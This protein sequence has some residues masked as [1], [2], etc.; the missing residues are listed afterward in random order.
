MKQVKSSIFSLLIVSSLFGIWNKTSDAFSWPIEHLFDQVRQSVEKE[1]IEVSI[2]PFLEHNQ[3]S[4]LDIKE[5][6]LQRIERGEIRME[7]GL[8]AILS[9]HIPEELAE[10]K[11]KTAPISENKLSLQG[12]TSRKIV[13]AGLELNGTPFCEYE[14]KAFQN[15]LGS[16]SMIGRLPT[17]P[18]YATFSRLEDWPDIHESWALAKEE[19]TATT[20]VDNEEPKL[21]SYKRCYD[22]HG[23]SIVGLWKIVGRVA[24]RSYTVLTDN[25]QVY[26]ISPLYFEVDG[27]IQA[28]RLNPK[29]GQLATFTTKLT[30][31]GYLRSTFFETNTDSNTTT[32]EDEAF[33]QDHNF[34]YQPNEPEFAEASVFIHA[35][36]MLAFFQGLGYGFV[37]KQPI[38]LEVHA[39][40]GNNQNNALYQPPGAVYANQ[41]VISIGDG[42]G[43]V[44]K[45]LALDSDVVSHEFGHH[46]VFN[47]LKTTSGDS[48]VLH[49][50]LADFFAFS[51][52]SDPCLGESICP[53]GST[54]CMIESSCLRTADLNLAYGDSQYEILGPHLKGQV[55]SG[56]L[57]NLRESMG[58]ES[59]TNV[60]YSALDYFVRDTGYQDFLVSLM[61]ADQDLNQGSNACTIYDAAVAKGLSSFLQ[62]IDCN[63]SS[64]WPSPGSQQSSGNS[65]VESSR[66]SSSSDSDFFNCGAIGSGQNKNSSHL[67]LLVLF[68]LPLLA[69]ALI[70]KNPRIG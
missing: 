44:L 50:G 56:M 24:G 60:T 58:L 61:L 62:G 49:E 31:D 64:S 13:S 5:R 1:T 18:P 30:G 65:T 32:A 66:N 17:L 28:Y 67:S 69:L 48:L 9:K 4:L 53:A 43:S 20:F 47:T 51:R 39:V 68:L 8:I 38:L 70:G 45:N 33:S 57:W 21:I 41:A 22:V 34:I 59:I 63:N 55:V 29:D 27:N 15:Q 26:Q 25:H 7:D 6:I 16:V 37:E 40:L 42:D 14:V 10:I 3:F 36:N 11:I 23:D 2:H 52:T 46:V 54:S 12:H 19:I 35:T